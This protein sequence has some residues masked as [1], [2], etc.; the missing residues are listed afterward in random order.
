MHGL[1]GPLHAVGGHDG[2]LG[3]QRFRAQP[4][5]WSYAL[6]EEKRPGAYYPIEEDVRGTYVMNAHDPCMIE[7]LDDLGVQA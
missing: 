7:H 1:F 5:R 6:V 4:C 3:Q 2:P